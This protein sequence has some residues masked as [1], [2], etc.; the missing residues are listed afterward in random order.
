MGRFLFRAIFV[1]GCE[2]SA[3]KQREEIALDMLHLHLNMQT[4][5]HVP[6]LRDALCGILFSHVL[7]NTWVHT[8]MDVYKSTLIFYI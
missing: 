1:W 8:W 5:Q 7:K 6:H 2:A 4:V 3:H